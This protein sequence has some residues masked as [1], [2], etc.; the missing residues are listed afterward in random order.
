MGKS[1]Q[2]SSKKTAKSIIN[3]IGQSFDVFRSKAHENHYDSLTVDDEDEHEQR[4]PSDDIVLID[5]E[6]DGENENSLIQDPIN[7]NEPVESIKQAE[8]NELADNN[9]FISLNFSDTDDEGEAGYVDNEEDAY[10]VDDYETNIDPNAPILNVDA[11]WIQNHDH[12]EQKEVADWLTMEINDFVA[13][14]S[15]SKHEIEARNTCIT[16]LRQCINKLW[17]DCEV[18]VFG[19]SATDLYLPGSDIDMVIVS[20]HGNYG[21]RNNLYQLSS[22]LK[23]NGLATNVEV[24]A[25]ARVPIIK[26]T[27]PHTNIHIDISFERT[28]GIQA[29]TVILD[30]L[31]D[32]PALRELVLVIKQFLAV[33]KLNNVRHGG[34]GGYSTICLVY[35]F[36]RLH[37][38]ISTGNIDALSNLGV[39]LIEFFELYGKNFNYD[40]VVICVETD[41]VCY[42]KKSEYRDMQGRSSFT[43]AI[44]DPSDSSNNISR[45][46][47]NVLGLKKAFNGA[48]W[49]LANQCYDLEMATYKQ[50]IGKSVL[51]SIVKYRGKERDFNDERSLVLNQ[52]MSEVGSVFGVQSYYSEQS[53]SS[54]EEAEPEP[55][56]KKAKIESQ[57]QK[58]QRKRKVEDLMGLEHSN[59]ED[60]H[61]A[62]QP[63]EH[64][65]KKST[66]SSSSLDKK[67]KR[68]YW[69]QKGN[70]IA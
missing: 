62:D 42:L 58:Q 61:D 69:T 7:V 38:R 28:N 37:P 27:E 32:T 68:D 10:S 59:D 16:Q 67:A 47:F 15:P 48:F 4:K 23:R 50:R 46:S 63:A 39:L 18:H 26:L 43:L 34:L 12:S 13:Y 11:P 35:S 52:A 21:T 70:A 36:L 17:K 33:R 57:K 29:A 14:I 1:S 60:Q 51:G 41:H 45:G 19:S 66:S 49:S 22:H 3:K 5:D 31:K 20:E 2:K 30:W 54:E 65:M 55:K 40:D 53:V 9:D 25:H 6:S 8:H 56:R 24:V 64:A 44:M